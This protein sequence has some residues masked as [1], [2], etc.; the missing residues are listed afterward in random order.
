MTPLEYNEV[1]GRKIRMGDVE[2]LG[3]PTQDL[4]EEALAAGHE[5]IGNSRSPVPG[6]IETLGQFL[7]GSGLSEHTP[8]CAGRGNH[9]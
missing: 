4:V 9:N 3:V 2:R 5:S 8:S 7:T 1:L 6:G